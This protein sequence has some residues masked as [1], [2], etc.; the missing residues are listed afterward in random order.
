MKKFLNLLSFAALSFWAC[1]AGSSIEDSG[2]VV[3]SDSY[4]DKV[5]GVSCSVSK[6][7]NSSTFKSTYYFSGSY[8]KQN[9]ALTSVKN[10]SGDYTIL[11]TL[12][13]E[14]KDIP[15]SDVSAYCSSL[16]E[17][18]GDPDDFTC[19]ADGAYAQ[20]V[21]K[22]NSAVDA[23][24]FTSYLADY[25][26]SL[27][28]S[29]SE[30]NS[31]TVEYEMPDD[32]S[33]DMEKTANSVKVTVTEED[34]VVSIV[35]SYSEDGLFVLS[36]NFVNVDDAEKKEFCDEMKNSFA[37][38]G[39]DVKCS[40]NSVSASIAL[41]RDDALEMVSMIED[42]CPESSG[43]MYRKAKVLKSFLFSK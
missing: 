13:A 1:D 6:S 32:Y 33:C 38:S 20:S 19:S 26:D 36:Y 15:K 10:E 22:E 41:D 25:C 23:S 7:D 14:F 27:I 18:V 37:G 21:L 12:D 42:L 11:L 34:E 3:F 40:S 5:N 39:A 31:D 4:G 2:E 43:S 17:S 9:E 16:R 30:L 35:A 24:F 28:K 8:I 29:Q